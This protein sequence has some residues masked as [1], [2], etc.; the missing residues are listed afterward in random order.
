MA[1][2]P[3]WE[4][5]LLRALRAPL[6][7]QNLAS[8]A[9]WQRR[10]GGSAS[11]NPLNTTQSAPGAGSYNSVGVRSYRSR[12]QGLQAT[13]KTLLN[14]HYGDIV[15][16]LK[17]GRGVGWQ[18]SLK[19]WGTGT[20]SAG[21][22]TGATGGGS[23]LTTP[24]VSA[25][26]SVPIAPAFTQKDAA[27]QGLKALATGSYDPQKGLAALRQ[28]AEATAAAYSKNQ[29]NVGSLAVPVVTAGGG[30]PRGRRAAAMVQQY[31]GTD[32]VWGGATPKGFD[33]SGLLQWV[34]GHLGVKISR[35]TYT[36]WGE[37]RSVG[38]G[39]L[40]PGDAVFFRGS[41]SKG[42]LPGHVG[43][44]IGGGEFVEAPHTG[45]TVHISKLR[46]R[47]DYMGA[48]RYG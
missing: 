14:G 29:T 35:T 22:A 37:G 13:V 18:Q 46:G 23:P 43:M 44:Y 31:L 7:Q 25:A 2:W 38:K 19:T 21:G 28:A 39:Q 48:R 42:G 11:F 12:M 8:L 3:Q 16:D 41:D 32:Y 36:Q 1:S 24:S 20:W 6:T 5:Q 40:R 15:S 27:M 10:E 17:A 26:P 34:W 4:K 30:S 45:S 47:T 33:C 9:E